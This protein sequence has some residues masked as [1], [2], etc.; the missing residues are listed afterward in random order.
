MAQR[1]FVIGDIHGN[2]HALEAVLHKSRF[3]FD[4]DR[5]IVIGDVADGGRYTRQCVDLLLKVKD[6]VFV[7]GNHDIW[8]LDWLEHYGGDDWPD[9]YT[10]IEWTSQGGYVT[11]ESYEFGYKITDEHVKFFKKG[12]PYYLD[13][14]NNLFVHGGIDPDIRIE[15]QDTH[16]LVWDRAIIDYA[17]RTGG[18]PDYNRV[19]I[20]HTSTGLKFGVNKPVTIGNLVCV[21]TGRML[22]LVEIDAKGPVNLWQEPKREEFEKMMDDG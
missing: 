1:T 5:L 10:P 14:A 21:D 8:A 12:I 4:V 22:S 9:Y 2:V 6:I 17:L 18:V 15:D 16:Y 11:M 7:I 19:Y 3:D 20:G 13:D